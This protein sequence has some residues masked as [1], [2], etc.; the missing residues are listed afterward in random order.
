M[1]I[2][3]ALSEA[4]G[5]SGQ[6]DVVRGIILR[7]IEPH[8]SD[9]RIDAMGN[10]L[11]RQYGTDGDNRPK[12]MLAAHM[13]EI[14]FMVTGYDSDGMLHF[15]SVGG[16]DDRILA[17]KRV[18]VG[19]DGAPGVILWAPIHKNR[20]QNVVKMSSLR[21]DI[22]A[23][24]KSDAQS[25]APLG[26]MIVFDSS[27]GEH[28]NLLR[29][30]A[31]DDRVGC[32]VLVDVLAAGPYPA[33][34]LVAFTVQEEVGLRGAMVATRALGPD[35]GF[36]LECTTA[37]DLPDPDADPDDMLTSSNPTARLGG[38][39][40]LTLMD[41]SIIVPPAMVE[42]MRETAEAAGI[43]YQFKTRLGGGNDA[44]QM[45]LQNG[46]IPAATISVP[47][48]Y[49]HSPAAL[50]DPQDYDATVQLVREL[51]TRMET[52]PAL[53]IAGG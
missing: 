29:G 13:D 10:L 42:F 47:A 6:E 39:P 36:S 7:A 27:Y 48:R 38:G 23:N 52:V 51:I 25:R 4:A 5:I 21:I 24:S 15:D 9:I 20:D 45:A 31:F 3:Q 12:I 35:V 18:R 53:K 11:A 40:A 16:V 26:T 19:A 22:G 14:G 46:G 30:K 8:V 49:I 2:L 17:G 33:D 32:S 41:R 1:K 44:G 50:I 37:H 28:G 34:V 43:P